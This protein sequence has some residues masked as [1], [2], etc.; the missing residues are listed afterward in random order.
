MEAELEKAQTKTIVF[1]MNGNLRVIPPAVLHDG[2]KY[3]IEKYSIA[4]VPSWQLTEPNRPDRAL[5]PQILAMGLSEAVEG[6][7]PLPATEIE[8]ATISSRVLVGQNFLN[9]AFTQDN[10][11]SQTSSQKFG[12]I[13]LATH[14]KFLN[15]SPEKSFIQ[16]WDGRLQMNQISQMNLTPDLLTLSACETAVGQHLGLAGLAVD[17]GA[18]SVLASLWE[19]SDAGTVPLMIRFYSGLPTAP[20][21]AI[22]LQEAQL[23]LL[24]GEIMIE[25]NQIR[26]IK[27]F[28][29]IPFLINAKGID[30]KHPYFWSSFTLIGNWL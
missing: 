1:V 23:T 18:K 19:V 14:A 7:S 2:K 12:I 11:R 27:G 21:K 17:S 5:I 24:R 25:N 4:S 29:R 28:P 16:F 22:A 20:T 30:L 13:H 3:L 8:V 6:L 9:S 15:E 10:L 26:G